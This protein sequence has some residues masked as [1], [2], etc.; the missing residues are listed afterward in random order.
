MKIKKRKLRPNPWDD[1]RFWKLWRAWQK[2]DLDQT[3]FG[4]N[5]AYINCPDPTDPFGMPNVVKIQYYKDMKHGFEKVVRR[6]RR[7]SALMRR[8]E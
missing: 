1:P 5:L 6:M 2:A 4:M 7:L 3:D 8:W